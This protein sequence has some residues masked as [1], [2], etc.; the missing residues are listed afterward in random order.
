M[1]RINYFFYNPFQAIFAVSIENTINLV[2]CKSA[3]GG[4]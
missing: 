1:D 2:S 3:F 4:K